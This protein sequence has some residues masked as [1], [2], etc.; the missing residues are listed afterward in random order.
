MGL[1]VVLKKKRVKEERLVMAGADA[2]NAASTHSETPTTYGINKKVSIGIVVTLVVIFSAALISG[3]W[4]GSDS[5]VK[6]PS[7]SNNLG[8]TLGNLNSR[9][10]TVNGNLP[11]TYSDLAK[12]Q[13][14]GQ[15][16][17]ANAAT[18]QD[19]RV[20]ASTGSDNS[21]YSG[22]SG[23]SSG[24]R[25]SGSGSS[26]GGGSRYNGASASVQTQ[27]NSGQQ[28][29]PNYSTV[30]S[31]Q[32][33]SKQAPGENVV[34]DNYG[35]SIQFS[36]AGLA[37][38]V[39]N[40]VSAV[41]G[42]KDASKDT[43]SANAA[44]PVIETKVSK[45]YTQAVENSLIAGTIIPAVLL[46]GVN[47]DTPGQVVAQVRQDVY[48]SLTGYSVLIPQGSRLIGKY[49]GTVGTGQ[50]RIGIT[51]D[52]VIFP[53]GVSYDLASMT[54]VDSEG[55]PGMKDKVDNHEGQIFGT[56]ALTSA[57]A[58]MVTVASGS[59]STSSDTYTTGQL[60]AQGAATG[61]LNAATQL[62]SKNASISPTIIIRPGIN[63]EV[64]VGQTIVL[65]PYVDGYYA[66]QVVQTEW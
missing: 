42:H 4:S 18:A 52:T 47:S 45:G 55:Y 35:S 50:S 12:Y 54:G 65:E 62:L 8:Q 20:A 22:Y 17:N 46:T 40:A 27:Q 64:F 51:W 19:Q 23:S 37:N 29:Y 43:A 34:A 7:E 48:D 1:L 56:A 30:N 10:S 11:T 39:S 28:V 6:D 15:K 26:G 63:F 60:A 25:S 21:G 41:T 38:M 16:A 3:F 14:S 36:I 44:T 2:G 9:Q 53:N 57:L 59:T 58:A 61:L 5:K 13:K 66:P 32:G 31:Q 49:G 33:Q 24:S